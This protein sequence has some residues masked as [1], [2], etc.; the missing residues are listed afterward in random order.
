MA[1]IRRVKA[2][3]GEMRVAS[4]EVDGDSFVEGGAS[5]REEVSVD[6]P[7]GRNDVGIIVGV[8]LV[9]VSVGAGRG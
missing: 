7:L 8:G 3:E 2:S 1:E 6:M 9:A 5:S 4:G